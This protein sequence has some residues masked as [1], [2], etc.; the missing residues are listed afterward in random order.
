MVTADIPVPESPT[1]RAS[2][3][4]ARDDEHWNSLIARMHN[5]FMQ[6]RQE[7]RD[8][9]KEVKNELKEECNQLKLKYEDEKRK[10]QEKL[11][12]KA[13]E[14]TELRKEMESE[15]Q[16][17]KAQLDAIIDERSAAVEKATKRTA[18]TRGSAEEDDENDDRDYFQEDMNDYKN[19][20]P[21]KPIDTK[22]IDKPKKYTG[23]PKE[24]PGWRKTMINVLMVQ[25]R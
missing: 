16:R 3:S 11:N 20:K 2:E 1:S 17:M 13:E 22:C 8:E 7:Y 15:K 14:Y 23:D 10:L 21:P 6:M 5:D 18:K 9:I 19:G 4:P 24:F 12:D 25:D